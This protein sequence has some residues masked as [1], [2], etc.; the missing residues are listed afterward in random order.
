MF[1]VNPVQ[2]LSIKHIG[3]SV[4]RRALMC[5][6]RLKKVADN[7]RVNME[8]ML[9][10]FFMIMGLCAKTDG[11]KVL[12]YPF[13]HCLNSHLLNA[14]KLAS[15]LASRGHEITVLVSRDYQMLDHVTYDYVNTTGFLETFSSSGQNIK[16][17]Q[18]KGPKNYEPICNFDTV[19]FMLYSPIRD[20]FHKCV[21]TFVKYCD[22]ILQNQRLL[23]HLKQYPF[24]V[25]IMESLDPCSR[26]LADFLDIPFIPLITTGLGHWDGNFRP[27]SYL[28]A[29]IAP[30]TTKM[31]FF[32]RFGNLFLK[33][34]YETLP[35][36]MG[37]DKPFEEMKEKYGLNTSLSISNTLRRASIKLVNS[38]FAVDYPAPIEPDTVLIGGFSVSEPKSLPQDLEDFMQSAEHGVIVMSFGTL[39]SSFSQEWV[40][41]FMKAFKQLPYKVL[42]K[43]KEETSATIDQAELSNQI[44]ILRWIPQVDVLSHPKTKLFISH[45]GLNGMYEAAAFGVPVLAIPLSGDQFNHAMKVTEYLKMGVQLDINTMTSEQLLSGI[46][47][48]LATPNYTDNA[49]RVQA[50]FKE[51]PA[52]MAENID[53]WVNYVVKYQGAT[54]L[55]SVARGMTWYEYF[56]IDVIAFSVLCIMAAGYLFVRLIQMTIKWFLIYSIKTQNILKYKRS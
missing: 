5:A 23:R 44:K 52:V 24:D 12:I 53:Y 19:E 18:F 25:F 13:G 51:Q 8:S 48:V 17:L 43:L 3:L 11:A 15:I 54:H 29:A 56:S 20:R 28:P 21:E 47:E 34:L 38:N 14:E 36:I 2:I 16:L 6:C 35:V 9:I 55:A 49:Q 41:I 50:R 37:F 1:A 42:W 32:Q 27:P 40:K 30:F 31:T 26:V 4:V 45:C 33:F 22:Q 46:S 39:V 7:I 10:F